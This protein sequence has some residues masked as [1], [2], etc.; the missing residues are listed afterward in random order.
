M[1]QRVAARRNFMMVKKFRVETWKFKPFEHRDLLVDN[2]TNYHRHAVQ[3]KRQRWADKQLRQP[4]QILA[5]EAIRIIWILTP[6][7]NRRINA[8]TLS[9]TPFLFMFWIRSKVFE[10]TYILTPNREPDYRIIRK[11]VKNT[12][13]DFS[14]IPS[15]WPDTKLINQRIHQRIQHHIPDRYKFIVQTIVTAK[16]NQGRSRIYEVLGRFY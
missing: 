10:P 15:K 5:R 14:V 7:G 3:S 11:M 13:T 12:V 4:E 1:H 8:Q 16:D 6:N 9:L 2:E